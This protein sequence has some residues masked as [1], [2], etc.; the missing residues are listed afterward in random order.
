MSILISL[1]ALVV[2]S[3]K[4]EPLEWDWVG[5]LVGTLSLLTTVL[6]GWNIYTAVSFHK[7]INEIKKDFQNNI[8]EL[9]KDMN[10]L[11][12]AA[13]GSLAMLYSN[14]FESP[15]EVYFNFFNYMLSSMMFLLK[16]NNDVSYHIKGMLEFVEAN[17]E[18]LAVGEYQKTLLLELFYRSVK[19]FCNTSNV[20]D[21]ESVKALEKI[22]LGLK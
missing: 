9:N 10:N 15:K 1:I 4:V 12:G 3:Y 19:P 8:I 18:S 7:N 17:K 20:Q 22:L 6:I 5:V 14:R 13:M 16:N 2:V 11:Q 21:L